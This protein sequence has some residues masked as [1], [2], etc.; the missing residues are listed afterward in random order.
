M[1]DYIHYIQ[2]DI[3]TVEQGII[4]HGCNDQGVMGSGVALFLRQKY[5][6]IF[7]SYSSLCSDTD[8]DV[9]LLGTIDVVN[10]A[11]NL[12]VVNGITQHLY[13]KDGRFALPSAID[14]V[15]KHTFILSNYLKQ[16]IYMPLIGCGRGGL[17]WASDVEPI[18]RYREN[19]A[20]G[21]IYVC[22]WA[23]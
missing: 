10:V 6:E 20:F 21:H 9:P 14:V 19:E 8:P 2:K 5:P 3:T 18:L 4:L 17:N 11:R 23:E 22:S 7:P 16:D 15:F 1:S 12:Y 13:G